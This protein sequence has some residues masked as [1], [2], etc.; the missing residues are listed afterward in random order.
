MELQRKNLVYR[1]GLIPY[2]VE[3]NEVLMLFM[4]PNEDIAQFSTSNFQIAKGKVEPE[5]ESTE[6]AALR[7]GLEELGVFKGN[8]I[9]LTEVGVFM[10]RT[11]VFV[12]KVKDKD[13][14]GL[15]SEETADTRWMTLEEFVEE[16]RLLHVPVVQACH[17]LIVKLEE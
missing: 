7:E 16:G 14:F 1:A 11:T 13:M 10:G 17:R 5:D 15:P 6:A 4:T 12:A 9:R 2:I 8:I 3:N